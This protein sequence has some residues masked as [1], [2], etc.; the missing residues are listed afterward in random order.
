VNEP[1]IG[2]LLSEA[3]GFLDATCPRRNEPAAR[4]VW[5]EG[6]DRVNIL[7]EVEPAAASAQ[8]AH[9]KRYAAARFDAGF[10]WIDGPV[11]CLPREPKV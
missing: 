4:F 1:S 10:G 2:D 11:E 8:L 3:R 9:A 7:E 6:S 5:G